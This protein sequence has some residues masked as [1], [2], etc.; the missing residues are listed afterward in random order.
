MYVL[1][2]TKNRFGNTF[3]QTHLVTLFP[4]KEK[5]IKDKNW[6]TTEET[7][8]VKQGDQFEYSGDSVRLAGGKKTKKAESGGV[9]KRR[10]I[11]NQS[12]KTILHASTFQILQT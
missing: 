7:L 2:L 4:L 9:T 5:E 3:S 8:E 1:V 10:D 12:Y 11:R 6:Q